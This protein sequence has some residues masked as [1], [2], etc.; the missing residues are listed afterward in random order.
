MIQPCR[1]CLPRPG[2]DE[3]SVR[4]EAIRAMA[5]IGSPSALPVLLELLGDADQKVSE[6]AQESLASLQGKDVD[7][8]IM[9][10]LTSGAPARR[11]TAMDLIVR[12][13]MTPAIPA[14]IT[15]AG[16]SDSKLRPAAVRSWENWPGQTNCPACSTCWPRRTM[17]KTWRLWSR[18]LAQ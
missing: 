1:L 5:E 15:I 12:R 18:P 13:R 10:M 8:A 14:L 16:G 9:Q 4:V 7:D 2:A 17:R 3:E 6:A 11:L